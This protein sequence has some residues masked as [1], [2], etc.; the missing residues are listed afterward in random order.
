MMKIRICD[1]DLDLDRAM[2]AWQQTYTT[3][4]QL[5]NESGTESCMMRWYDRLA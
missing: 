3:S 4:W 2:P 5:E 1:L